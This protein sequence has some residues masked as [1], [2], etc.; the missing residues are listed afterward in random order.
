MV[1]LPAFAQDAPGPAYEQRLDLA[2]QMHEIWPVRL[3]VEKALDV[4]AARMVPEDQ[5]GFKAAMRRAIQFDQ[6]EKDSVT[7]MAQTFT[8]EELKAMIVFYGSA[9]GRSVSEKTQDYQ[10][11]L[12]PSLTRMLDAALMQV[13]TG[14]APGQ[15]PY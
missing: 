7:A 1:A 4:I 15:T 3:K 11:R 6:L 14:T 9:E 8:A 10:Q 2:R 5:A 12:E 13:K